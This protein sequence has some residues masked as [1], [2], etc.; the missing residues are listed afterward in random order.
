PALDQ[1]VTVA[2]RADARVRQVFVQAFHAGIVAG[3]AEGSDPTPQP[4]PRSGEG[5]QDRAL[6]EAERQPRRGAAALPSP[7]RGGARGGGRPP[8]P[9]RL[10][11]GA[12]GG[13]SRAYNP[14]RSPRPFLVPDGD[15]GRPLADWLRARLD[16]PHEQ[17]QQLLRLRRVLLAGAPC[18]DARRR[19]RPG[20]RVEVR[21]PTP[22]QKPTGPAPLI[23]FADEHI[24]VVEKPSGLTTMRHADAPAE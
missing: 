15:A 10:G 11:G 5:E 12:G 21:L 14:P 7:L 17:V 13:V 8:P 9:P 18:L 3:R 20:Q 23:R 24:V 22:E 6:R 19:L 16:L 2:A 4:P 1:V